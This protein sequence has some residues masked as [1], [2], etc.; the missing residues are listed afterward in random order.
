MDS[1]G[2]RVTAG[3]RVQALLFRN[4]T[5]GRIVEINMRQASTSLVLL[6]REGK[7]VLSYAGRVHDAAHDKQAAGFVAACVAILDGLARKQPEAVLHEGGGPGTRWSMAIIGAA[8]AVLALLFAVLAF[9]E[10]TEMGERVTILA[11]SV[12]LGATGYALAR[13]NN[14]F[15]APP[16]IRA[17]ELAQRLRA[18]LQT[19]PLAPGENDDP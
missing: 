3:S 4:V 9:G 13:G 18:I 14:P 7:L 19:P 16:T 2:V 6:H 1:D 5:G 17:S 15:R 10:G 8:T 12:A 11:A